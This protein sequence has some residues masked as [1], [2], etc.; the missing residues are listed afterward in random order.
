MKR[1]AIWSIALAVV[2][3]ATG[4]QTVQRFAW[5]KRDKAPEDSSAVARSAKPEL[6]S[7]QSNPQAVAVAG[8]TPAAPPSSTNLAASA[9]PA[10]G[11]TAAT[12][13]AAGPPTPPSVSIPVTPS[14]PAPPSAT[15]AGA[16]PASPFPTDNGLA[17]KLVSS[18]SSK[19]GAT[20]GLG[21][22]Q[23][24]SALPA[25]GSL[26]TP[27]PA[28]IAAA[29]PYDPNAY[30]P[31][32]APASDDA[33]G[34]A[35][36]VDRYAINS[37]LPAAAPATSPYAGAASV[38]PASSS[39]SSGALQS[40][41]ADRYGSPRTSTAPPVMAGTTALTDPAAVAADRYS[42]P[43]LPSLAAKTPNV[44]AT[45]STASGATGGLASVPAG[46]VPTAPA[47]TQTPIRLTSAPG[48][49]RPGRTSTYSGTVQAGA[50][51]V[52]TRPLAPGTTATPA[53][54]AP[55]QPWAPPAAASPAGSRY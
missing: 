22:T 6:P 18:P 14:T 48:Q 3:A 13:A 25:A 5:F 40:D 30:K 11:A 2:V 21:T 27:K 44:A 20:A 49:F 38:P 34:G 41:P 1:T 45:T 28:A 37:S 52:A 33:A 39:A 12:A 23:P 16:A 7:A 29:G 19:L 50:I 24:T 47:A 53:T 36:D 9:T 10:I 35:D 43:T 17:D 15:T 42:N 26:T 54:N 31:S 55:A 8:L 51:Q 4:C 32:A 46:Q